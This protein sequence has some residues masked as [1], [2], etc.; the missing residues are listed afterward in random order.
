M[1]HNHVKSNADK[2]EALQIIHK[3]GTKRRDPT[4]ELQSDIVELVVDM[5]IVVLLEGI[6]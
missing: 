3:A 1:W 6:K 2:P 4:A 5:P